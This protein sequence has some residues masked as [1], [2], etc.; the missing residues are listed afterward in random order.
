MGKNL[1]KNWS[2]NVGKRIYK[3][4]QKIDDKGIIINIFIS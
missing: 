3:Y 1:I 4:K 2:G